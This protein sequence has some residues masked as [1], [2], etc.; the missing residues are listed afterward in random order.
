MPIPNARY[1]FKQ[2]SKNKRV[3]LAFVGRNVVEVTCFHKRGGVY[4]KHKTIW[5]K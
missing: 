5:R 2:T 3:R 1:R 4:K